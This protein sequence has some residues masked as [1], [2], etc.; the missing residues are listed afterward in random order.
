MPTLMLPLAHAYVHTRTR[1]RSC[2]PYAHMRASAQMLVNAGASV[3]VPEGVDQSN[4]PLLAVCKNGLSAFAERALAKLAEKVRP[5]TVFSVI[6]FQHLNVVAY[7][8]E[9]SE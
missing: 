9:Y 4:H 5:A 8:M 3:D 7:I 2:T 6:Y 1:V